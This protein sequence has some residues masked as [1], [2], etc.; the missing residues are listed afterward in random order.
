MATG[1]IQRVW[2]DG[3]TV[4]IKVRVD[5]GGVLGI[6]DYEAQIPKSIIDAISTVVDKRAALVA[7]VKTMRD[8][9]VK[10]ALADVV[11]ITGVVT[12]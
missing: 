2:T 6:V 1:D 8:E 7:A 11:G 12:L 5:E 9:R 4:F 10:V 3:V